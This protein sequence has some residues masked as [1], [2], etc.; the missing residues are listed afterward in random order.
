MTIEDLESELRKRGIDNI[1]D[2][3]TACIEE[4]GEFSAVKRGNHNP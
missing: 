2:V 3:A 1:Q 4:D